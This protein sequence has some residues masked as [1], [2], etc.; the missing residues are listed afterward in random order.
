MSITVGCFALVDPFSVLEHQLKRIHDLGFIY[1]DVTD[2]RDGGQL[3]VEFGFAATASLDGNPYDLKRMFDDQ[4]LSI[5]T[6]CAH[7]NLLDPPAPWRYGTS[8]IIKAIRASSAIGVEYV[9]TTEGEPSTEFGH[10]MTED[11]KVFAVMEKLYEPLRLAK[12]YG[13]TLLLEN[14]GEL[15]DSISGLEKLIHGLGNPDHLGVNLDTG[16]CWLGGTNP[17]EMVKVFSS[18]IKHVH[19]KD[20]PKDMEA[21]RGKVF[22]CGMSTIALGTGAIDIKGVY[23]ELEKSGFK[24]HTTLEIAGDEAVLQSYDLLKSLGA[25]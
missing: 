8:Q 22:G 17:V 9:V 18:K 7:A 23:Q 11:Q 21:Q 2:N 15:T 24:G 6:Y 19:W 25:E 10:N 20:L 5:T 1:A 3:G 12:D 13:V 16:N 4:G 14:H